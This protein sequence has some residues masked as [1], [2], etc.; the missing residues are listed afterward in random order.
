V[1]NNAN[2]NT[3][4]NRRVEIYLTRPNRGRIAVTPADSTP[5]A[6]TPAPVRP[7]TKQQEEI[8]K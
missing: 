1:P 3:P 7:G 8:M 2:G 5:A 4:Q 6:G